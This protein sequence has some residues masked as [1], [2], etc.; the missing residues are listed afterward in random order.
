MAQAVP[1][2]CP[3]C[4]RNHWKHSLVVKGFTL[5][6]DEKGAQVRREAK[7]MIWRCLI[8]NYST[9]KSKKLKGTE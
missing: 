6:I 9:S 3:Q 7:E 8:C 1:V 5:E 2:T 4:G